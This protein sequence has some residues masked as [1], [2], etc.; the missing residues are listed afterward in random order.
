EILVGLLVF[1]SAGRQLSE[2]VQGPCLSA[3]V[4]RGRGHRESG[5][6]AGCGAR[7]IAGLLLEAAKFVARVGFAGPM[8][9]FTK[10]LE[11][12]LVT[13][14]GGRIIPGQPLHDPEIEVDPGLEK[15]VTQLVRH[16]LCPPE[17]NGRGRVIAHC[18][19]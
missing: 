17:A 1:G 10:K 13:G 3:A 11:R 7:K 6:V 19:L 14:Y 4:A 8:A 16:C 9:E 12:S 5:L 2:A 18:Y 15:P